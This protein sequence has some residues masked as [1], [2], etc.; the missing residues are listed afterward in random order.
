MVQAIAERYLE[1]LTRANV[2][3]MGATSVPSLYGS[4]VKWSLGDIA[5]LPLAHTI[6]KRGRGACGPIAAWRAAELRRAGEAARVAVRPSSSGV[7]GRWHAVVVRGDGSIE[8][9]SERLGMPRRSVVGQAWRSREGRVILGW[10]RTG[11]RYRAS[12]TIPTIQR[13]AVLGACAQG[14][15]MASAAL[16][17]MNAATVLLRSPIVSA[18]VPPQARLAIAAASTLLRTK[19]GREVARS[20]ARLGIPV[21]KLA[22]AHLLSSATSPLAGARALARGDVRGVVKA[23]MAPTLTVAKGV[24]GLAKK[25]KFW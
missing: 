11:G 18:I 17:T 4:G 22:V 24:K 7:S 21:A 3:V 14:D 8:D 2:Q 5:P 10:T 16:N 9:P 12:L 20:V 23:A 19:A 13:G 25:L 6:A 1:G 15:T